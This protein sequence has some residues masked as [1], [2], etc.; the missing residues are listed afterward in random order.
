MEQQASR[1]GRALLGGGVLFSPDG[2]SFCPHVIRRVNPLLPSFIQVVLYRESRYLVS[3]NTLFTDSDQRE[4]QKHTIRGPH[5]TP[6]YFETYGNPSA[7]QTL[8]FIHGAIQT[9]QC[10]RYQ[11]P[12]FAQEQ[13]VIGL[14]LPWHGESTPISPDIQADGDTWGQAV[15]AVL[16]E[17]NLQGRRVIPV[18]WSMGGLAM[19]SYLKQYGA[20]SIEALVSVDSAIGNMQTFMP[21]FQFSPLA[22]KLPA[23]IT[24]NP[25]YVEKSEALASFIE[26][27]TF[28]KPS[29]SDYYYTYG[30]NAKSA[31]TAAPILASM[32]AGVEGADGILE[33]LA[34][35][36]LFIQGKQDMLIASEYT[37]EVMSKVPHA[38]IVEYDECGHSPFLE[39]PERFNQDVHTFIHSL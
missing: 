3:M 4:G 22:S 39:Y 38:R 34:I 5:N 10:W 35:P 20:A 36:T 9:L 8:I 1:V 15:H 12:F 6:L 24:P 26:T 21:Y 31:F 25:P 13:Y 29:L 33:Q 28:R 2:M 16:E 30:Y 17:L 19:L 7:K 32:L 18:F 14:D 23:L 27:L 11:Y 37:H